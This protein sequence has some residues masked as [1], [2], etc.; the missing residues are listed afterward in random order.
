VLL[1]AV[2][3]GGRDNT[4]RVLAATNGEGMASTSAGDD[5]QPVASMHR[6]TGTSTS[7][8]MHP[9]AS[10]IT[11]YTE[12][13]SVSPPT[14]LRA[15]RHIDENTRLDVV[16]ADKHIPMRHIGAHEQ[17]TPHILQSHVSS[18]KYDNISFVH[19]FCNVVPIL[20]SI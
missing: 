12:G 14:A 15:P 4:G 13:V 16:G 1:A 6:S 5:M 18:L 19:T 11:D 2:N 20:R 8:D 3:G 10:T 7:M 9:I 17:D